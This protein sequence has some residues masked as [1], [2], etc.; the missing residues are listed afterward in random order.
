MS[1]QTLTVKLFR[2]DNTTSWG[3]RLQGGKDFSAPLSVQRVNPGS[4]SEQ[5]G[6]M[7]GDAILKIMGHATENMRHKEAQ[8]A[9]LRAGNNIELVVQRGGV[10]VWKPT[11]T[12]VGDLPSVTTPPAAG[13]YTKTSLAAKKQEATPIGTKHNTTPRPFAPLGGG[14]ALVNNQYNSPA[15]L[16]S[17][18]NIADT[19][20]AHT[21]VLSSG[22]K[23]INFMKEPQ[24]VNKDSAVYRMIMEEKETG[25]HIETGLNHVD[26]PYRKDSP[27]TQQP[28]TQHVSAPVT[29]PP[30]QTGDKPLGPNCCPECGKTI[31]GVFVRIKDKSLHPECFKCSTCGT[32]LK[33]VGYFNVNDKLY[34]DAHAKLA[35]K[36]AASMPTYEPLVISQPT[37]A[38][39]I[40]TPLSPT[41]RT[42][43]N[44]PLS[45][46]AYRS[47][48]PVPFHKPGEM[49][50]VEAPQSPQPLL[51]P[52]F[53][54]HTPSFT[55][56]APAP[57]FKTQPAPQS[58]APVAPPSAPI[59]NVTS[60][61]VTG[62]PD[63]QS[64]V[65]MNAGTGSRPAPKRGRG[66]MKPQAPS[67][68]RIPIC[69]ICGTPIRGPFVVAL[70][71]SWCPDH[72][73]CANNRCQTS[74][75]NIGFVEDRGQLYCENCYEVHLA[76]TCSKCLKR[77]K[78][79]CLNALDKQWHPNCFICCYCSKPFGNSSFYMEDGRP[80]CEKD[81]NE[82]FTTKCVGCGFPIEAGDRWVEAL[83]NNYHSQ[84][85]KCTKCLKGLEGQSFYAKGGKPYCKIHSRD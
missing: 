2:G 6:L 83:N 36:I 62:G 52:P 33:N 70:G 1:G 21:E 42:P 47:V 16:Y 45:P 79:D 73:L 5:A 46:A 63:L 50:H 26:A 59:G 78:G 76:P 84:C 15:P 7:T 27:M 18:N 68:T 75:V 39:P 9:I 34:C 23:G 38:P 55:P 17:M 54:P 11:V 28:V 82:L 56:A 19:L 51:S 12:P 72:F 69:Q 14:K 60:T 22:A 80:Y 53:K 40:P 29:K 77:I 61:Q 24:P 71:K 48:S 65:A 74:L 3:F 37:E 41:P 43:I 13:L 81:W 4:L 31:V 20:S 64:G 57:S 10:R 44:D 49:H 66:Q 25:S 32:S 35:A 8:D 67:G 30:S 85:F 58:Q